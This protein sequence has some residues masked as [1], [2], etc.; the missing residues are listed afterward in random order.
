MK[1]TWLL[2]NDIVTVYYYMYLDMSQNVSVAELQR[3]SEKLQHAYQRRDHYAQLYYRVAA[4]LEDTEKEL[5]EARKEIQALKSSGT[6]MHCGLNHILG[7][8]SYVGSAF[9]YSKCNY[10]HSQV[11]LLE[12]F[13][14][15]V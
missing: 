13:M 4:K 1:P 8:V 6:A 3:L 12:S 10:I 9:L 14:L 11:R 2:C 5:L 15:K 7:I